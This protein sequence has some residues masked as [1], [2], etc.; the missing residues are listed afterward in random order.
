MKENKRICLYPLLSLI[1]YFWSA[2]LFTTLL[3]GQPT[4]SR[5]DSSGLFQSSNKVKTI[6]YPEEWKKY[7]VYPWEILKFPE[8]R[9]SY[10]PLIGPR[11]KEKWLKTL[12]G[13]SS[14][15]QLFQSDHEKLIAV[16]SCKQ[17]NCDR[18]YILI[19]FDPVTYQSWALLSENGVV[20][21]FGNPT[22]SMK[23]LLRS[24]ERI[25]WPDSR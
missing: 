17:H 4:L 24:I 1:F 16:N 2:L 7:R 10:L 12:S 22:H 14:P 3:F 5:E 9:N 11:V 18:Q 23:V 21:W 25:T 13:P 19:L 8:F 20:S 6:P 15:A